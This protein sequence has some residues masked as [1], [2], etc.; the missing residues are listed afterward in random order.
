VSFHRCVQHISLSLIYAFTRGFIAK[1][2][3]IY[4]LGVPFDQVYL[5]LLSIV[6]LRIGL[7][8]C[9]W[10]MVSSQERITH[11]TLPQRLPRVHP[12]VYDISNIVLM[13]FFLGSG[14]RRNN[15]LHHN[16]VYLSALVSFCLSFCVSAACGNLDE[17]FSQDRVSTYLSMSDVLFA[18][19]W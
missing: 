14:F 13:V 11:L 15:T 3:F 8:F 12:W 17:T 5:S 4:N 2:V 10:S 7:L 9:I 18:S 19:N 16:R 6:Y 1:T